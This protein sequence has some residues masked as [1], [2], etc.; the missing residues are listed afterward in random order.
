Y[1]YVYKVTKSGSN[2]KVTELHEELIHDGYGGGYMGYEQACPNVVVG[3][4]DGD[5]VD[6]A[7]FVG[8]VFPWNSRASVEFNNMRV[9]IV[10]YNGGSWRYDS[11]SFST[12]PG[13]SMS[14]EGA[15]AP[16]H[17]TRCDFDGDGK[18]EIAILFFPENSAGITHP[19]LERWYCD[20]GSITPQRDTDHMKGGPGDTSVFGYAVPH[21]NDYCIIVEEFSMTAGPLTGT[22][23]KAKLAEDVAIS[24]INDSRSSVYVIPTVLDGSKNFA[25]FGST[26]T[27]WNHGSSN[28]RRGAIITADFANEALQLSEPTH[29]IDDNDES[30]VTILQA[31]PYHVD[32]VD[33]NGNLMPY[34]INY[35]F[36]GFKGD[37]DSNGEMSV[38][39]TRT[40][41]QTT[42]NDV[43]FNMA[44]TTETIA[45]LGDAGPYV[46]DYLKFRT[47]QANIAGIFDS[48]AKAAADTMNMIMDFVTDKIDTTD[49][50][51]T[52]QANQKETTQVDEALLWDKV[53]S[54]SAQQHI[55]RYKI[56]N[57]PLPSWYKL[58]AKVDN[59]SK[60]LK[61]ESQERYLTFSIYDDATKKDVDT[62]ST[63]TYQAR[64][65]EGNFFSY[66]SG[67]S[68]IPGYTKNEALAN[69]QWV[70]W[71]KGSSTST[72]IKF[73][74]S[75]ISS[76]SLEEKIQESELNKTV[77]AIAALFG[78]D[79]PN[80]LPPYTGHSETFTKSLESAEAI[81]IGLYGKSTIPGEQAG[82]R[83]LSM[84]FIAREGTLKVAHAVELADGM[85][86]RQTSLLWGDNSRY[87]LH[88]DPSLVLPKKFV[89]NGSILAATTNNASA[90]QMRGLRFY[91]PDIDLLSD[92]HLVAGLTY[93]IKVPIYNAS[94]ISTGN[95]KVKLSYANASEF[96]ISAP[97]TTMDKL[98][99]IQ[100]ITTNLKGWGD[101]KGWAEFTWTIPEGMTNG[102][103]RFFVQIDP[104]D[105]LKD[106][107]HESRLNYNT[108]EI[109]DVGGNNEG[110]FAFNITSK[111]EVTK[112]HAKAAAIMAGEY[113]PEH[114]DGVICSA[115]FTGAQ[116][117]ADSGKLK[118]AV[119]TLDQTGTLSA[120]VRLND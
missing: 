66:P 48:R 1:L 26:K 11:E 12:A 34:L 5:G 40:D 65:E 118:A 101:N 50:N 92:T 78:A 75:K 41:K 67:T 93:E 51:S 110:Y 42:Q 91:V 14:D 7:A 46:H 2:V 23:G 87:R 36:S 112:K 63:N 21:N 113:K 25:G 86:D 104:A 117:A 37:G 52:T 76:H 6:E 114:S 108:G 77:S 83:I 49:T 30:Y 24:H 96:S 79:D 100:T 32:N 80:P 10:D 119:E 35:T 3:D 94:F 55:W 102:E 44:S 60:D 28:G 68:Q 72:T 109:I 71:S 59:I 61:P 89:R 17:A 95:F 8:R 19:R 56:L 53:I 111:N 33:V 29:T 45:L 54:Y 4:F 15:H 69:E 115:V 103:Y 106:E 88:P 9:G 116:A 16:C 58:G 81:R 47:M 70:A 57:D 20:Y 97:H 13:W 99:E 120:D 64:H 43:S 73:S 82:H 107:V 85:I 74:E 18:D 38:S 90:M 31:M 22:K 98:H 39:Y 105:E 62:H 84:P 27:V